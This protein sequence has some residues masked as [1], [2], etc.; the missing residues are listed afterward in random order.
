[1]GNVFVNQGNIFQAHPG[2]PTTAAYP[3]SI[4]VND[5]ILTGFFPEVAANWRVRTQGNWVDLDRWASFYTWGT[6]YQTDIILEVGSLFSLDAGWTGY[7]NGEDS[8][9]L[10]YCL[11]NVE[12]PSNTAAVAYNPWAMTPFT[13]VSTVM[14]TPKIKRVK[15]TTANTAGKDISCKIRVRWKLKDIGGGQE[16]YMLKSVNR[17]STANQWDAVPSDRSGWEA[18]ARRHLFYFW[19][20]TDNTASNYNV[21]AR[22]NMQLYCKAKLWQPKYNVL[23]PQLVMKTSATETQALPEYPQVPL[24]N[25]DDDMEEE[26]SPPS[27]PLIEQLTREVAQLGNAKR[28][29]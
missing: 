23:A 29:L 11:P 22:W 1:M 21:Q 27:T 17:A 16:Q 15:L 28:R 18:G 7:L 19:M 20:G 10:Y 14:R 13:Q 9:Y 4:C 24:Q 5:M 3:H 12:D 6:I 2:A 26:E 25:E 8:Y